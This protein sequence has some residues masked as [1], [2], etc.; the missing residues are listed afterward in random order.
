MTAANDNKVNPE[1]VE[2]VRIC[3]AFRQ[4]YGVAL[5]PDDGRKLRHRDARTVA[6]SLWFCR[7]EV[8]WRQVNNELTRA[9]LRIVSQNA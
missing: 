3:R 6:N 2:V 9:N 5:L 4:Q 8:R 7:F 1:W